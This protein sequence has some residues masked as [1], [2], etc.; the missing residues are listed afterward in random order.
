ME[1]GEEEVQDFRERRETNKLMRMQANWGMARTA[2][3]VTQL[4]IRGSS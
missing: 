4:Q 1:Y 3:H 2:A